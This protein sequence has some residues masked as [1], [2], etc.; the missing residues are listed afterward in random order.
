[1][2]NKQKDGYGMY[3]GGHYV[4]IKKLREGQAVHNE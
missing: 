4:R 1:M 2:T 3:S